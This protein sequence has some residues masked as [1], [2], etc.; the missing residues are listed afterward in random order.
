MGFRDDILAELRYMRREMDTLASDVRV[1]KA[2]VHS[3]GG[4]SS[5]PAGGSAADGATQSAQHFETAVKEASKSVVAEVRSVVS[6][7]LSQIAQLRAELNDLRKAFRSSTGRHDDE[8]SSKLSQ[9]LNEQLK[10]GSRMETLENNV[11]QL[12]A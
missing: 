4:G 5:E 7:D 1:V 10:L 6:Q 11:E 2:N 8:T 9:I 12:M 3:H